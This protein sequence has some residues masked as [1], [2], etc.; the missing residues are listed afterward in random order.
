MSVAA[1]SSQ[2]G[3]CGRL[4]PVVTGFTQNARTVRI[5]TVLLTPDTII[6][7][8]AVF[9]KSQFSVRARGNPRELVRVHTTRKNPHARTHLRGG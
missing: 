9:L 1:C 7:T 6:R 2:N 3:D 4:W 5:A 8:V